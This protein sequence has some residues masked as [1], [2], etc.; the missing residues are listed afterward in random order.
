[1][2]IGWINANAITLPTGEST[3]LKLALNTPGTC[4][5]TLAAWSLGQSLGLLGT[6]ANKSYANAWLLKNSAN[7]APPAT[8]DPATVLNGGDFR[9]FNWSSWNF[10]QSDGTLSSATQITGTAAVGSTPDPCGVLPPVP[11][12][13]HPDNG[14][15]GITASAD[16]VYQLAEGRVGTTGQAVNQTINGRTTP[17]IWSVIEFGTSGVATTTDTAI[18][19]A[20]SVYK[21][22]SRIA[23]Y[24][25]TQSNM[26]AF[27]AKTASYQRLP[28]QIE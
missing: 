16:A 17:Y 14:A 10:F 5:T 1:M 11:G 18:F 25:Q 24:S 23:T 21:D 26:T 13:N 4:S 12:Q 9:L 22:G 19:P 3:A 20:Y 27:I 15:S 2:V 28:S 7:T 6:A 8:I